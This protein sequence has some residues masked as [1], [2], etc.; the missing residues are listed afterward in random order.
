MSVCREG[1]WTPLKHF[2]LSGPQRVKR[3]AWSIALATAG[4]LSSCADQLEARMAAPPAAAAPAAVP[5]D[6]AEAAGEPPA[7][8]T[9]A[10]APSG[11]AAAPA[12]GAAAD[13]LSDGKTIAASEQGNP[14]GPAA[15][16]E[17]LAPAAG[18]PAGAAE[19]EQAGERGDAAVGALGAGPEPD[20]APQAAGDTPVGAATRRAGPSAAATPFTPALRP[21][22]A[23][24]AVSC[25]AQLLLSVRSRSESA[26]QAS[27][28]LCEVGHGY[29]GN[30]SVAQV[31]VQKT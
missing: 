11:R 27:S 5:A 17:Q 19:R 12:A 7:E 6:P 15:H 13:A 14:A 30:V 10:A 21:R 29:T 24:A 25:P 8:L 18:T 23:P 26:G 31:S 2:P 1:T 9:P 16:A 4:A 28:F 22:E 3:L 20:E